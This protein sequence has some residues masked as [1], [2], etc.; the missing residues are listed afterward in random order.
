MLPC[1]ALHEQFAGTAAEACLLVDASQQ[2]C[3]ISML[4]NF[5]ANTNIWVRCWRAFVS[6]LARWHVTTIQQLLQHLQQAKC[7]QHLLDGSTML[8][9]TA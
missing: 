4:D 1:S 6:W 2:A 8:F 3:T 7:L 9:L 5:I